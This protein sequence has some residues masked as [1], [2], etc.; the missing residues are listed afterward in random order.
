MVLG[1]EQNV[2]WRPFQNWRAFH[3]EGT[4]LPDGDSR[5]R[6]LEKALLSWMKGA[7][8]RVVAVTIGRHSLAFYSFIHSFRLFLLSLF[9]FTTTQRRSRLQLT[10]CRS[11]IPKCPKQLWV[12]DFPKVPMWRMW[13]LSLRPSGPF[14]HNAPQMQCIEVSVI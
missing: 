7:G 12:K 13:A 2:R 11:F 10:L 9:K 3:W 5:R 8:A 14:I 4:V 1:I 6:N